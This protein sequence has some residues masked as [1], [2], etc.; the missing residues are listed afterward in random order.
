MKSLKHLILFLLALSTCW[1]NAQESR[2]AAGNT[3]TLRLAGVP[4]EDTAQVSS[5]YTLSSDGTFRLPY[6][7][8]AISAAGLTATELQ[9][10]IVALYKAAEIYTHPAVTVSLGVATAEMVISVGGEVRSPAEVPF[11]PGINL[12]AAI[13]RAGGPTEY[14][15]M[16]KVKLLRGKSEKEYD[17]RKV[18]PANNPELQ[19][20]DQVIVPGS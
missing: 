11:R 15:N 10:K 1:I 18:S 14:A 2:L 13:N 5:Q 17:L 6:L 7:D 20:G 16:K 9:D 4:A 8:R 19:A 3:F 12:F